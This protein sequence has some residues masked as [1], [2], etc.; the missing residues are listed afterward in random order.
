MELARG[1]IHKFKRGI[2]MAEFK[3]GEKRMVYM[4]VEKIKKDLPTVINI[5]GRRYVYD[6]GTV[7]RH[8]SNARHKNH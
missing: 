8:K 3:K 7:W 6:P 1:N 4:T 2:I 5:G